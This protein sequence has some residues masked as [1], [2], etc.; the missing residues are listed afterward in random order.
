[1]LAKLEVKAGNYI[2]KPQWFLTILRLYTELKNISY[3]SLCTHSGRWTSDMRDHKQWLNKVLKLCHKF[4]KPA[5]NN[6]PDQQ[7]TPAHFL[8]PLGD[9]PIALPIHHLRT[10]IHIYGCLSVASCPSDCSVDKAM[11]RLPQ[12]VATAAPSGPFAAAHVLLL[13][14]CC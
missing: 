4:W 9:P 8:P 2:P 6:K 1:L 5:V 3:F 7:A 11:R 14:A 12:T 13:L 10:C